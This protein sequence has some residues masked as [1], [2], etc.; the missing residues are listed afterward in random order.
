[1]V[2]IASLPCLEAQSHVSVLY[3]SIELFDL[4]KDQLEF[5]Q[6]LRCG[7]ET[8]SFSALSYA[9]LGINEHHGHAS[10]DTIVSVSFAK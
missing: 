8:S 4:Y 6:R 3:S 7:L 1:M 9:T 2:I 10:L 5:A